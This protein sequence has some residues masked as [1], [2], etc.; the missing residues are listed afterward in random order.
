MLCLG[1]SGEIEEEELGES[2]GKEQ[3]GGRSEKG[4]GEMGADEVFSPSFFSVHLSSW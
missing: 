1:V 3:L 2:H 4:G